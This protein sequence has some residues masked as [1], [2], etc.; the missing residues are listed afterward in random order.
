MSEY[1]GELFIRTLIEKPALCYSGVRKIVQNV[2]L[3]LTKLPDI[4]YA[5]LG[6]GKNKQ[7]QLERNYVNAEEFN[8]VRVLLA[9]RSKHQFTSVALSLRGAKKD[10]RSMGHCMQS[11]VIS[12][13]DRP[14]TE[15]VEL[16]YRSTE[17]I[18]KFGGDI[19]FL[20]WIF[21]QLTLNPSIIRFHFANAYLSG[22][23]FPTLMRWWDPVDF[24]D[25][26]WKNDKKLFSAGTRFLLRSSYK[27]DQHFP[28]SPENLQHKFL[29]ATQGVKGVKRIKDYLHAQHLTL[30]KPL[31]T[32]HH[33]TGEYVPR[34]KRQQGDEV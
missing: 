3:E 13:L 29:W 9:A 28:Y 4:S 12:R 8:R 19:C 23:F 2:D 25:F 22:V 27:Q 18:L 21:N 24:L 31:P 20:P 11:L 33:K 16:Q 1:Y 10:S 26:L 30:G 34:A 7:K 32:M 15:T 6:Y 17:A 14:H 5:D